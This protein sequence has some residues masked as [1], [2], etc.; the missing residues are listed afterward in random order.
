MWIVYFYIHRPVVLINNIY[1]ILILWLWAPSL[2]TRGMSGGEFIFC[3]LF[4]SHYIF[5]QS[6]RYETSFILK[7]ASGYVQFHSV[8]LD[9]HHWNSEAFSRKQ[10]L[11]LIIHYTGCP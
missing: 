6:W 1:D 11:K 7:F 4:Y 5:L 3:S 8:Q 2:I 10:M 9:I